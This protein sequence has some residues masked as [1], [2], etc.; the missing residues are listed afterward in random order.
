[1]HLIHERWEPMDQY[2]I[3]ELKLRDFWGDVTVEKFDRFIRRLFMDLFEATSNIRVK[4]GCISVFWFIPQSLNYKASR[5]MLLDPFFFK[6]L[7]V[8]HLKV[9]DEILYEGS[10]YG[11]ETFGGSLLQAIELQNTKG[12]EILL[13]TDCNKSC[14]DSLPI[15]QIIG[16]ADA[17]GFNCLYY[18]CLFGH[19]DVVKLLLEAGASPDFAGSE[20]SVTPL[21]VACEQNQTEVVRELVNGGASP[22]ALHNNAHTPLMVACWEGHDEIVEIM[23]TK[24]IFKSTVNH[25]SKDISQCTA[26]HY[27][28]SRGYSS[29][30][31]MLLDADADPNEK[32]DEGKTPLMDA[33]LAGHDNVVDVLLFKHV[34]IDCNAETKDGCTAL[35][36]ASM[37]GNVRIVHKLLVQGANPLLPSNTSTCTP[38]AV[39]NQQGY[40]DIVK[41]L[42]I[43]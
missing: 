8:L 11:C 1:M 41:L 39:A 13:A 14:R 9:D 33:C 40:Y 42:T 26:L 22:H 10:K 36:F 31:S 43:K 5:L 16:I 23:F 15:A 17:Q 27:A 7:G 2:S 6:V 37:T 32:D 35:Y 21:C 12:I 25:K 3:V 19:A 20:I 28:C 30:V 29:V 38:L 18:A 4:E 24:T 34:A